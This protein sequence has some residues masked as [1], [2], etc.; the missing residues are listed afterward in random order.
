MPPLGPIHQK[1]QGQSYVL[2]NLNCPS[3]GDEFEVVLHVDQVSL[4]D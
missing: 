4:L 3:L 2:I 1:I